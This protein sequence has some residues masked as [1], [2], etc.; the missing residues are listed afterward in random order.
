MGERRAEG[1][2]EASPRR[3]RRL[4]VITPAV[5]GGPRAEQQRRRPG[6][7]RDT[8]RGRGQWERQRR[9]QKTERGE[10]DAE[11]WSWTET[12]PTQRRR[13][14]VVGRSRGKMRRRRNGVRERRRHGRGDGV[15]NR[16]REERLERG[17]QE[18][19]RQTHR[20]RDGDSP[21]QGR[22]AQ[23]RQPDRLSQDG[24]ELETQRPSE[25][26][27]QWGE[28]SWAG[29]QGGGRQSLGLAG[30]GYWHSGLGGY[31]A[32]TELRRATPLPE[33]RGEGGGIS[34]A[35]PPGRGSAYGQDRP[36]LPEDRRELPLG[37]AEAGPRTLG[38]RE[39]YLRPLGLR[40]SPAAWTCLKGSGLE[41]TLGPGGPKSPHLPM[42]EPHSP[43]EAPA[44]PLVTTP[45][46]TRCLLS[47]T[48]PP[49][50]PSPSHCSFLGKQEG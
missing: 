26:W 37:K 44:L 5:G 24:Q 21:R 38:V 46:T 20:Q 30:M 16:Q 13:E 27:K 45:T 39:I 19:M 25:D 32:G 48:L 41:P 8:G 17:D 10:A 28:G 34:D 31:G 2:R 42:D 12:R 22:Q 47:L 14:G 15:S 40:F 18:R 29:S 11:R 23:Q 3:Q 4:L 33:G 49:R 36:R 7:G 35:P 1:R 9:R 50:L 43:G 6:G